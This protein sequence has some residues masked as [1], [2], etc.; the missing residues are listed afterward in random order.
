MIIWTL[1]LNVSLAHGAPDSVDLLLKEMW[2]LPFGVTWSTFLETNHGLK[3]FSL[4][5]DAT[6]SLS[7]NPDLPK[8]MLAAQVDGSTARLLY[9]FDRG[10]LVGGMF[11]QQADESTADLLFGECKDRFG[12]DPEKIL[13]TKP[14]D[15]D[16]YTWRK[17][18]QV[19]Q[20]CIQSTGQTRDII[21]SIFEI[22]YAKQIGIIK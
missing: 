14:I 12:L 21:L 5:V 15:S 22:N 1:L 7:P 19:I 18:D 16:L 2:S 11:G 4:G 17:Q 13:I 9:S 6:S 20:L 8:E 10:K 3:V